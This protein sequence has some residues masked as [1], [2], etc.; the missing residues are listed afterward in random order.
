METFIKA[1]CIVT[2]I[3]IIVRLVVIGRNIKGKMK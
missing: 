1:I 3:Y 2:M